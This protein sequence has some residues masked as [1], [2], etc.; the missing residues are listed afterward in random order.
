MK[1]M[2]TT[3]SFKII[4]LFVIFAGFLLLS[5][6]G[7]QP[8]KPPQSIK[9]LCDESIFNLMRV[10]FFKFDSVFKDVKLDPVK[11]TANE[12]MAGLLSGNA[13]VVIV[14]RSYSHLEDSLMKAYNV[15]SV[16]QFVIARDAI[17]FF[18]KYNFPLDTLSDAQI[19][20]ML[21]SR[22]A[23]LIKYYK[24]LEKEPE[25]VIP[26]N[27][28]AEY[29][30][31]IMTAGKGLTLN[32][33]LVQLPDEDSVK[34]Y[35]LNNPGNIGVGYLSQILGNPDIKPLSIGFN[36]STGTYIFPHNVHQANIAQGLYPYIVKHYIY[37]FDERNEDAN[38][39][40][41]FFRYGNGIVQKYFLDAGIVPGVAH[42][43]LVK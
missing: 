38:R 23:S 14:S 43:N 8:A 29:D 36:D 26:T 19:K 12:A 5:C 37:I 24:K 6:G 40:V 7:N 33:R 10:P 4:L 11:T 25:I 42:I 16:K 20:D 39:L 34:S 31:F 17:V 13:P 30:N 22:E 15:T 9:V 2:K 27:N 3:N 28:S 41:N 21:S 35:I 32:K 18:A 1:T